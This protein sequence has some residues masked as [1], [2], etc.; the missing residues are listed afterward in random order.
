MT[1]TGGGGGSAKARSAARSPRPTAASRSPSVAAA[2]G[3][4]GGGGSCATGRSSPLWRIG[5]CRCCRRRP[6]SAGSSSRPG[7]GPQSLPVAVGQVC[8]R[9][10][11]PRG[12]GAPI[13]QAAASAS[14]NPAGLE[15]LRAQLLAKLPASPELEQLRVWPWWP[16]W[17]WWDCDADIIFRATQNCRGQT[18]V[19]LDETVLQTRYDIPTQINVTLTAND[20]ACCLAQPCQRL[21]LPGRKLH[22]ADR[23]LWH[24]SAS[25]GGNPGASTA[26]ATIGYANPGGRR[27][28]VRWR[29]AL[30][31][32]RPARRQSRRR[33][34][35]PTITSSSGQRSMRS[36]SW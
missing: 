19:I 31:G 2:A 15:T 10:A 3:I 4:G 32:G 8:R 14:F 25:V 35:T 1:S 21:R 18:N 16:W 33:V 13:P 28:A 36:A 29:S 7:A 12:L 27:P 24:T 30:L 6:A 17:P 20:E 23:Y 9:G 26:P 22:H 5:S 11:Q 34:S